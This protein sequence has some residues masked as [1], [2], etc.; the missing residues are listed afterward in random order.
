MVGQFGGKVSLGRIGGKWHSWGV[1]ETGGGAGRVCV[2]DGED[3]RAVGVYGGDQG[4]HG[5]SRVCREL[6]G[7][8][9]IG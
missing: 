3:Q 6:S 4:N 1:G 2:G 9:G 8:G 5:A 7:G